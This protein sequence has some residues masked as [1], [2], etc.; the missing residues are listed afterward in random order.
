MLSFNLQNAQAVQF[1]S[2]FSRQSS[3]H[4]KPLPLIIAES[5]SKNTRGLLYK[6]LCRKQE[7]ALRTAWEAEKHAA[8]IQESKKKHLR[9]LT[10][11][12][13]SKTQD[14][15]AWHAEV[16]SHCKNSY[17]SKE[18]K[19]IALKRIGHFR[20]L[21]I[22]KKAL[23]VIPPTLRISHVMKARAHH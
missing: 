21:A 3:L 15:K 9:T 18:S 7:R 16:I 5:K 23:G 1:T 12:D 6:S 4:K 13:V 14:R 10:L 17:A 19:E 11:A 22:Q 8:G 20:D 2:N